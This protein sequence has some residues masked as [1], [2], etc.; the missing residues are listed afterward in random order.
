MNRE[1]CVEID[2]SACTGCGACVTIC[3]HDTLSI[4]ENR[5]IVTG[6]DSLSCG[7]CAAVCPED[8][9][10]L[11]GYQPMT[12]GF[13]T[14]DPPH[15]LI[16]PGDFDAGSLV[17]LM[18]SRRS[19]RNFKEKP[20]PMEI[21]E[22][23]IQAGIT[24]PSGTNAQLWN[25]S[26]LPDRLSVLVFSGEVLRF[27]EKLN[28]LAAMA[29]LRTLLRWVGKPELAAYH[30]NY[31]HRIEEGIACWKEQKWD[32]LF[33][34]APS[35]IIVSCDHEA[36][37]GAED[38]L[39]ATGQI[40]LTAHAMG[41]AT[42]LIGFAVSAMAHDKGVQEAARIPGNE[43]AHAVIAVGWPNETYRRPALRKK[44]IPR[45]VRLER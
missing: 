20:V 28:R 3:P 29:P 12:Q 5:A 14:F 17:Q 24:A 16:K 43:T 21:L 1:I 34:G 31:F 8:A 25:F 35:A 33:H 2:T 39:L 10:T 23:L 9:I 32:R 6:D 38:A 22:D 11:T 36:S 40:L 44:V 7:H 27:F 13:Q 30:Q 15:G 41:L 45:V 26:I 19:C 42:C 4:V 18:A 37:C